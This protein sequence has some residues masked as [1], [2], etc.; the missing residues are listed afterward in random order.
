VMG[1]RTTAA[2]GTRVSC[3]AVCLCLGLL[4]AVTPTL[5]KTID[6]SGTGPTPSIK[7]AISLAQSGDTIEV[8]PGTY[9]GN[10]L[11]DK[12]LALIGVGWPVIRGTGRGSVITVSGAGSTIRGF[13]VEH[14]GEML[15]DED[16]GIL[17]KS[18]GNRLEQNQLRD[19][20]F[21][22]YLFA[23]EHNQIISNT[24]HGRLLPDIGERGSG[25]HIWN[26]GDNAIIDNTILDARDG[27]YLQNA[28]DS[29]IRGNRVSDLRYGLHYMYSD[30]NVF[31]DNIFDHN[32]A[33]AA[34]M[35]SRNIQFRRNA[36]IH[37]R[38][39]SSFGI[40]FQGTDDCL[41][42]DNVIGDNEVGLFLEA[43][44]HSIFRRNL[45]AGNDVALQVFSSAE[46]NTFE[47]NNFIANLSP[48]QIVG[49]STTTHWNGAKAGNYWSDY[50]GYD[51]DADGIGDIPYKIQNVFEHMEGNYPRLR[52]YLLSPASQALALAETG[53]PI[54]EGS[55]EF[56]HRPLMHPVPL[57]PLLLAFEVRPEL[58]PSSFFFPGLMLLAG[59][60]MFRQ[61]RK[62]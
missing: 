61:G 20:L 41:A 24:I 17:L 38:G 3:R 18:N 44:S 53:F 22:I 57:S 9:V 42:E 50:E 39:F 31:E 5:A 7:E 59:V 34:I 58:H 32:V 40:L 1:H 21:G 45:I 36:F 12:S 11:I 47:S 6:V 55:R 13:I 28:H 48:L 16:S 52:V 8:Q 15:V 37:N 56:D 54:I 2:G 23:S 43:H 27:M 14:S 10:L 33:G 19:V 29:T 35:Y 30:D 4:T 46:A 49:R 26:A 62:A 51:L 60:L 25:I